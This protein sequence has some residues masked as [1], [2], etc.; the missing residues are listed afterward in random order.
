[1]IYLLVKL[2]LYLILCDVSAFADDNDNNDE[3]I[4]NFKIKELYDQEGTIQSP[5][6]SNGIN[7]TYFWNINAPVGFQISLL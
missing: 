4:S 2:Y 5:F 1:M 6:S 3:K 7:Q